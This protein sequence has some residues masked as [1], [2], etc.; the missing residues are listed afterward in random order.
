MRI[1][2]LR[3]LILNMLFYKNFQKERRSAVLKGQG[4]V[5]DLR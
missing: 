5:P 1:G 4:S 2:N 3:S